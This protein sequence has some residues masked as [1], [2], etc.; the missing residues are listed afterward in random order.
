MSDKISLRVDLNPVKDNSYIAYGTVDGT[1]TNTAFT[2]TV[3]GVTEYKD[4]MTVMLKNGVVTSATGFTLDVNSLGAK[5]VYNSM[6]AATQDTTI[7]N[8]N[9]TMLFIYDSTRVTG[10]CWVCYRGYNSDTNTIGYQIRTNSTVFTT[11]DKGYRY[12]LWLQTDEGKLMPV[13]TSTSTNATANRSSYMNTREFWLDGKILYNSTKADYSANDSLPAGTMW[14]QY[15]FALGYS[16]NNTGKALTLT[17]GEPLYMVATDEG[18]GKGKLASPYY[19]QTLPNSADGKL[20]IYLGHM[21]SAVNMELALDHPIFEYKNNGIRLYRDTYTTAEVDTLLNGKSDT[22]HTHSGYANST[23]NHT[24]SQITDFPTLSTVAT[25]GS[26]ND[27]SDKPNI[28]EGATVD[29]TLNTSSSNAISNSAVAT[30]LNGKA[31]TTHNHTKSQITDFPDI[32]SKTSDLTNDG[33]DG[34]NIYVSTNDSRLS[35]NRT[36][37]SHTHGNLQ[38]DGKIGTSGNASKNVVT[39]SNGKITTEDK[40]SI[41]SASSTTPSADTINGSVGNGTTWARSNHTHPKSSLYAESSHSHTKSEISDFPSSMTPASHTHGNLQDNGQVGSTVQTSKNVVT[42]SNGKITTED[43]PNIPSASSTAPSADT[44]SGAVGTGNT[45]AR[46]DHKHPKSTI[47]AEAT[48]N[49]TISEIS[50]FPTLH[51][52]ATSGSYNDLTNKP[53][54]PSGVVVDTSLDSESDNAISNSAVTTALNGKSDNTHTHNQYLTS[55]Q[56]ITG[57]LDKTQTL[58]KGKN[59]VVDST[60]GEIT[61]EDKNNHSHSNYLTNSDISGKIDTAGTGLS[62]NG[63]TLNH[64]NSV[65]A[66]NSEVFKKFKYDA[67]GHITGV[68]DVSASDLPTHTHSQYAN[69]T[70]V[71]DTNGW[72]STL[73]DEKVPSEKLVKNSLDTKIP[74]SDSTYGISH[75]T[76]NADGTWSYIGETLLYDSEADRLYYKQ[77]Y[78]DS[79]DEIATIGD[80]PDITGKVDKY[81]GATQLGDKNY[82]NYANINGGL[83]LVPIGE[84]DPLNNGVSQQY[85]NSDIND[86]LGE[87]LDKTQISYKG[88]NVVVDGTTGN[89]SFEDKNVHNHGH[90][91][92]SGIITVNNS[93]QTN[94]NVCTDS[95]GYITIEEKDNHTHSQYLTSNDISEKID[96]AGTGLSKSGTT[97]NHSNS[98]TAQ[99]SEVFKKFKYDAQGHITGISNVT[100]SDLPSHTHDSQYVYMDYEENGQARYGPLIYRIQSIEERIT[101]KEDKT[102]K[103]TSLSSSNTDTQYPSA[104]CVYDSINQSINLQTSFDIKPFIKGDF[105]TS[106]PNTFTPVSNIL[107]IDFD[108]LMKGHVALSLSSNSNINVCF[109][110][111]DGTSQGADII[112]SNISI[113]FDE[114]GA[115]VYDNVSDEEMSSANGIIKFNSSTEITILTCYYQSTNGIDK[116]VDT[117]YPNGAI[118]MSTNSLNP[119]TLFDGLWEQIK[120]KFL[121]SCGDTYVNGSIGGEATHTLTSAESGLKA[122]SHSFTQPSVA[123]GSHYHGVSTS[124]EYFVTSEKDG[125]NNTRVTYSSSGNRLVDGQTDTSNS[126]FHHRQSTESVNLGTKTATG[127]AVQEKDGENATSAHNNMPPYLTVYV[128]KRIV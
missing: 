54:I 77:N 115:T 49:H 67:T 39:D 100:D 16:F 118:Y 5:P 31:N 86:R 26:Y 50:D 73:S 74:T 13:N 108:F 14:Q 104:K 11:T 53:N 10:G 91:Q 123:L 25:T 124:S 48:H 82:N 89:I 84:N 70:I 120:D 114:N 27:L 105:T 30:A 18:D 116:F 45:W 112:S 56:D 4:G 15:N 46:A 29:T 117:I 92:S 58:H 126:S 28:P 106:N 24:K 94:K 59:V 102:N 125:A 109:G 71:T 43:K 1:S 98:I 83:L 37:T 22:G 101:E 69:P 55:H 121:L 47:Y 52:V 103:V 9:Y 65:T 57:K 75:F 110:Q 35:D 96:T 64:S 62:K 80:I 90:I 21:T 81:N 41:P 97:L 32:P 63:T 66:Q 23:H 88:K 44:N 3:T 40:P 119:H 122:H 107:T 17:S 113:N 95:S 79:R 111:W 78:T 61:F 38:N 60:S 51:A 8:I 85:I 36:P 68:S 33:S 93:P 42:D 128:W 19:T 72:N 87:K 6:A 12:R 34:T 7:F 127:G 76:D 2:A 20:Y 99:N